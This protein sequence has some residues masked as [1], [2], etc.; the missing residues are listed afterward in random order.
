MNTT[1]DKKKHSEAVELKPYNFPEH[2]ITLWAKDMEHALVELEK[3]LKN[4]S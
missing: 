2:N 1:K 3:H 4:N